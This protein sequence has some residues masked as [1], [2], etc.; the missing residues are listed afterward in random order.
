MSSQL[1]IALDNL[2]ATIHLFDPSIELE[3]GWGGFARLARE[4]RGLVSARICSVME[5]RT[6]SQRFGAY[7]FD[8]HYHGAHPANMRDICCLLCIC[9]LKHLKILVFPAAFRLPRHRMHQRQT[10][11]VARERA[12]VHAAMIFLPSGGARRTRQG[13]PNGSLRRH[14][15]LSR[16][17]PARSRGLRLPASRQT[18]ACGPG[19]GG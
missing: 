6:K 3:A 12:V 7:D 9:D 2:D 18:G 17:R 1:V 14:G 11:H 16:R 19:A 8:M 15:P 4:R 10:E 13:R 5:I